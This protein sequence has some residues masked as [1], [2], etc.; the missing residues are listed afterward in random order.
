MERSGRQTIV[1][2]LLAEAVSRQHHP[3]AAGVPQGKGEHA[4]QPIHE[5]VTLLFVEVDQYL[6]V[7][8]RAEGVPLAAQLVSQA[9]EVIDLPIENNPDCAVLVCERLRVC[10]LYHDNLSLTMRVRGKPAV[11]HAIYLKI[12]G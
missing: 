5:P 6:G 10:K 9:A 4:P 11:F 1:E 7:A 3:A 12:A 8:A 2:G